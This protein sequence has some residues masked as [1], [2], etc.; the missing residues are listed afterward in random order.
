MK[1][2]FLVLM[3]VTVLFSC[4]TVD[5][6]DAGSEQ[7]IENTEA[8]SLAE[9]EKLNEAELHNMK[10]LEEEK[11]V[12]I[13]KTIVYVE[14]PVYLPPE[15]PEP[16]KVK[17]KAAAQKSTESS[18]CEPQK[19]NHGTMY[20]DFDPDFTYIIYT[21]PYRV[22]DI[23]LEPGEQ[24]IEMP[25]LSETQ[26]WEVGAGVSRTGGVDTQHFFI[27][28]AC[29]ALTTSFIII[30][31]RRVYHLLL[32]SYKDAYMTQVKWQYP[33]LMPFNLKTEAMEEQINRMSKQT[34]GIDP[35]Y[36]SFDYKMTYSAFRKPYWIPE[37]VYDDG[38]RTYIVMKDTVLHMATPVLFNKS[39]Q[40]INYI[41][42][43]N[44]IIVDELIEKL[45]LRIG[46]DKVKITKK[47]YYGEEEVYFSN[48]EAKEKNKVSY[49][50]ATFLHSEDVL[51]EKEEP[52]KEEKKEEKKV[53][54]PVYPTH[55]AYV[56]YQDQYPY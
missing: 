45:T 51:Y 25:F 23:M 40:K 47:K 1:K 12:D 5:F 2:L 35:K 11:T 21:Q 8:K 6:E 53:S 19:Y 43:K 13:Q 48:D 39:N 41:V 4:R 22:T 46:K 10:V 18:I 50:R 26:V 27:K 14:K 38:Q 3:T 52:K 42:D 55:P 34:T 28:P 44:I 30:T 15:E 16:K 24:V 7:G 31:D 37:R 9:E 20:Y 49:S 33:N 54:D 29:T 36:L 17:G 32:K 56:Q